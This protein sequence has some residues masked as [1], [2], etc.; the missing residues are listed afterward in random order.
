MAKSSTT[1]YVSKGERPNVQ[2]STSKSVKRDRNMLDGLDDIM[3]AYQA[4]KNPWI[5]ISNPDA[6]A[7]NK[8]KIRIRANDLYG[9]P[10]A[11]YRMS[12]A[13]GDK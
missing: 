13:G 11:S 9:D 1:K 7:T 12:L 8:K 2:R 5:T 4:L 3:K 10:K 6:K